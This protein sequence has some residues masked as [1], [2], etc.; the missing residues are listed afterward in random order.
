MKLK[1]K[2]LLAGGVHFGHQRRKWNPKMEPYVLCRRK[3]VDMIDLRQTLKGVL[4]AKALLSQIAAEGGEILFV[5]TKLAASEA[6]KDAAT[7][8]S[9]HYV[10]YRWLG[11]TLTNFDTV[12]SRIDYL[13]RLDQMETDGSLEYMTKKERAKWERERKKMTRNL[14]GIRKMRKL[15]S[16]I[17][18]VDPVNEQIVLKEAKTMEIPVVAI[19]DTDGDPEN[20]DIPIPANDE[21]VHAIR[22]ILD[23][24]VDS[25]LE[26]KRFYEKGE[27]PAKKEVKVDVNKIIEKEKELE[28][29]MEE[30]K[31]S[32]EEKDSEGKRA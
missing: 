31:G 26:G 25:V 13:D 2:D 10:N 3:G 28:A 16:A 24:I 5:G 7:K 9:M 6:V 29:I 4:K 21:S 27:K 17:V 30:E 8:C 20:V 22:S 12:L 1:V 11:G 14:Q 23:E 32:L 19:I 18:V 15:P